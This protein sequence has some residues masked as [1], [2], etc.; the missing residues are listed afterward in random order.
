MKKINVLGSLFLILL[1]ITGCSSNFEKVDVAEKKTIEEKVEVVNTDEAVVVDETETENETNFDTL[2]AGQQGII[3]KDVLFALGND[4]KNLDE[5]MDYV[6]ANDSDL[7]D[8]MIYD[9]KVIV[10]TANTPITV[11][12]NDIL[13]VQVKINETG[14][15]G[16]VPFE[17]VGK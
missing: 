17:Y 14:E 7:V 13:S 3:V 2:S 1:L 16:W 4:K 8:Q 5:M 6:T 10:V 15:V 11:I 9:G 12:E